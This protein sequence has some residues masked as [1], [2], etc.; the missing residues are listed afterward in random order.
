MH[1][2]CCT[3]FSI[4]SLMAFLL[5]VIVPHGFVHAQTVVDL[6]V[7]GTLVPVSDVFVPALLQGLILDTDNPFAFNFILDTGFDQL[8]PEELSQES[9]RLIKYFLAALTIPEN[10]QWVNLSPY[11]K[12]RIVPKDFGITEMGRD[13]LAQDYLLKQF[14]ASLMNPEEE[15]GEEFWERVYQKA[16][17]LYGTSSIPVNTFNKVWI[18]PDEALVFTEGRTALILK[19]HL[20]V[21][22]EQDYVALRAQQDDPF[23]EIQSETQKEGALVAKALKEMTTP[24]IREVFLP[25]I[26]REVNEG[27]NF[28]RL[29]QVFHAV[30]LAKWYKENLKQTLLSRKYANKNKVTG[31]D[32]ADKDIKDKIYQQYLTAFK[33]GVYNLIKEEYDPQSQTVIPRK[34]FLGG[35]AMKFANNYTTDLAML[36]TYQ[37]RGRLVQ[38]ASEMQLPLGLTQQDTAML[39]KY[40]DLVGAHKRLPTFTTVIDSIAQVSLDQEPRYV[41][42]DGGGNQHGFIPITLNKEGQDLIGVL[43]NADVNAQAYLMVFNSKKGN[44]R[45][46]FD[47]FKHLPLAILIK[48][49]THQRNVVLDISQLFSFYWR[50]DWIMEQAQG[51]TQAAQLSD[52]DNWQVLTL[53]LNESDYLV[54]PE[55]KE[56]GKGAVNNAFQLL[57]IQPYEKANIFNP[58]FDPFDIQPHLQIFSP[59]NP[60]SMDFQ[61]AMAETRNVFKGKSVNVLGPGIG[62]DVLYALFY[63]A[64]KVSYFDTNP[65]HNLL[66]AW[67]VQ[68]AKDTGQIPQTGEVVLTDGIDDADLYVFNTPGVNTQEFIRRKLRVD[69]LQESHASRAHL[70][71]DTEFTALFEQLQDKLTA[72]GDA[73]AIWRLL[74]GDEAQILPGSTA[75][76][77]T[78]R[79]QNFLESRGLVGEALQN[80]PDIVDDEASP[81]IFVVRAQTSEPDQAMLTYQLEPQSPVKEYARAMDDIIRTILAMPQG[82]YEPRF[83]ARRLQTSTERL[84]QA[85]QDEVERTFRQTLREANYLEDGGLYADSWDIDFFIDQVITF[86]RELNTGQRPTPLRVDGMVR[87]LNTIPVNKM[88]AVAK[89]KDAELLATT[90]MQ[91][92]SGQS[93]RVIDLRPLVTDQG[94]G[95]STTAEA[96]PEKDLSDIEFKTWPGR[97]SDLDQVSRE[98]IQD[99]V[100][101]RGQTFKRFVDIGLGRDGSPTLFERDDMLAELRAQ[102]MIPEDYELLALDQ[103]SR[104]VE[105]AQNTLQERRAASEGQYNN[106]RL[107]EGDFMALRDIAAREGKFDMIW[108]LNVLYHNSMQVRRES[109]QVV[110][111]VLRE[112]GIFIEQ[113]VNFN[114]FYRLNKQGKLVPYQFEF[115]AN[116]FGV[117]SKRVLLWFTTFR[118]EEFPQAEGYLDVYHV[119]S[120]I[121]RA[122]LTVYYDK[123]IG[124][125]AGRGK[126]DEELF[127]PRYAM[128]Q[129]ELRSL[130]RETV[131]P[132]LQ[133]SLDGRM[134]VPLVLPASNDDIHSVDAAMLTVPEPSFNAM[135]SKRLQQNVANLQTRLKDTSDAVYAAHQELLS[136]QMEGQQFLPLDEHKVFLEKLGRIAGAQGDV[137]V[138]AFNEA[139]VYT[140][141]AMNPTGTDVVAIGENPFGSLADVNKFLTQA[142]ARHLAGYQY[143]TFDWVEETKRMRKQLGIRGLGGLALARVEALLDGEVEGLHYFTYK[144]G[145]MKFYGPRESVFLRPSKNAVIIYRDRASGKRKRFWYIQQDLFSYNPEFAALM[146]N[147]DFTSLLIKSPSEEIFETEGHE[148]RLSIAQKRG[149]EFNLFGPAKDKKARVVHDERDNTK[150]DSLP[151]DIWQLGRQPLKVALPAQ[152]LSGGTYRFGYSHSFVYHGDARD[153][154]A[155]WTQDNEELWGQDMAMLTDIADKVAQRGLKAGEDKLIEQTV[156]MVQQNAK[157]LLERMEEAGVMAALVRLNTFLAAH[158]DLTDIDVN[159]PGEVV[160]DLTDV[161]AA[162]PRTNVFTRAQDMISDDLVLNSIAKFTRTG[163][164]RAVLVSRNEPMLLD[165]IT[166]NGNNYAALNT[167]AASLARALDEGQSVS[168]EL[169][170][171]SVQMLNR[172]VAWLGDAQNIADIDAEQVMAAGE[173]AMAT[174]ELDRHYQTVLL[175]LQTLYAPIR[176]ARTE[177]GEPTT[178]DALLG[179]NVGG[180]DMNTDILKLRT[181]GEQMDIP[182]PADP[183]QWDA[184]QIEGLTPFI[185]NI[186]PIQNL[187]LLFSTVRDAQ[188]DLALR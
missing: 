138:N 167:M 117:M 61:R 184:I 55:D 77:Y 44:Y 125:D 132:Q 15:L 35:T 103:D 99:G 7:P 157:S 21:M 126:A 115:D 166:V 78:L 90:T 16:Y 8:E 42:T 66:T 87:L 135:Q 136:G 60:A 41:H 71:V 73:Q 48:D 75:D 146:N 158:P 175:P 123:N 110:E 86:T 183:G 188:D 152:S 84:L 104:I 37:K 23:E 179:R 74:I 63:G 154:K 62:V 143:A 72:S 151:H 182:I 181:Q 30:I 131:G 144:D 3:L 91:N 10:D 100:E 149:L 54:Y 159:T 80:V 29:R 81:N 173:Q 94:K 134:T 108:G 34:Y 1:K 122:L 162:V 46:E 25:E 97:Y 139:D 5:Q 96:Q 11:E 111:Q 102:Q 156:G 172:S 59:S 6:P 186:T 65:V 89:L 79:V 19:T 147:L 174:F 114:V 130:L 67:N 20:K 177:A 185:I 69:G 120:M 82:N 164:I 142:E 2:R 12:D 38:V 118:T 140:A 13:L 107:Q 148:K 58:L 128:F 101:L 4:V 83:I 112:D 43:E 137:I 113:N 26:E 50:S 127:A 165:M 170:K 161:L 17:D 14:T 93:L 76:T 47:D 39:G 88:L 180:I 22:L 109:R 150:S 187:P 176:A 32:V 85:S 155:F 68:Y 145:Q 70:M 153:I 51:V 92:A 49:E 28:S 133:F 33:T 9:N 40:H 121:Y 178:D 171:L 31:V 163:D 98:M 105:Q 116:S 169:L 45:G 27:S 129:S 106:I 95:R 36:E 64:E 141:A 56:A 168:L 124:L 119:M 57:T 52:A 53:G 160:S 24:I 18:V